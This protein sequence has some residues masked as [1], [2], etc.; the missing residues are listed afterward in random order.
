M[1]IMRESYQLLL[2]N[3][4]ALL[5]ML[6]SYPPRGLATPDITDLGRFLAPRSSHPT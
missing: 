1:S 4:A 5:T 3:P 6:F 2:S